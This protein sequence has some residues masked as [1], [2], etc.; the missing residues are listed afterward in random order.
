[1]LPDPADLDGTVLPLETAEDCPPAKRVKWALMCMGERGLLERF[2]AVLVGRPATQ[3]WRE[4]RTDEEREAYREAQR[5]AIEGQLRR[6]N[7]DAPV[8]FDLDVGHTNPATP[9]PIGGEVVVNTGSGRIR[10]R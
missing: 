9:V 6:Y 10:F 5:R 3:N 1:Y 4:P 7:P 2:D 8:V